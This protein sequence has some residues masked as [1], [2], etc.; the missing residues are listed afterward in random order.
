LKVEPALVSL[1]RA[2]TKLSVR[3]DQGAVAAA[4]ETGLPVGPRR[5]VTL[6]L[7]ARDRLTY[8]LGFS[9]P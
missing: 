2:G 5:V 8:R 7:R 1:T 4:V 3:L 9:A 6:V